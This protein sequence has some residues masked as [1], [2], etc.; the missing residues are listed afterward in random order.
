MALVNIP[1]CAIAEIF[2]DFQRKTTVR[3]GVSDQLWCALAVWLGLFRLGEHVA[4][5]LDSLLLNPG[6][7]TKNHIV[8]GL[9]IGEQ[10]KF[11]PNKWKGSLHG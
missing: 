2:V 4:C 6:D 11:I 7:D 10:V 5:L 1:S 9:L 8:K 3:C